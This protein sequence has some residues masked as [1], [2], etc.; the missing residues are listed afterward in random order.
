MHA[1]KKMLLADAAL[2]LAS[3]VWGAGYIA[4][5]WALQAG[6]HTTLIMMGRF[7]VGTLILVLYNLRGLR[8]IK[9][10]EIIDGLV[11][12]G[13][14]FVSFYVQIVAQ[15]LTTVSHNAFLSATSVVMVPF[16]VW[17]V[18]RKRPKAKTFALALLML[19]GVA[20]LSFGSGGGRASALGDA[21][22]LVCALGYAAHITYMGQAV[23]RGNPNVINMVQNGTAALFSTLA[24]PITGIGTNIDWALGVPGVLYLGVFSTFLCY[25]LQTNAQKYTTAAQASIL[26]CTEGMFGAL[27]SVLIGFE[28]MTTNLMIGGLIITVAVVLLEIKPK[29]ARPKENPKEEAL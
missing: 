11:A 20:V 19:A 6:M 3:V 18:T 26:L 9:K 23:R 22:T 4:C 21:L 27:F 2:L 7:W 5:E 12:G 8:Q 25:F 24:V 29:G 17:A 15:S 28:P 13:I 14:L 10:R 16:L 1:R